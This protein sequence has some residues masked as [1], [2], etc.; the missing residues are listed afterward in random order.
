MAQTSLML[1]S[2]WHCFLLPHV[3]TM[4]WIS[5][6]SNRQQQP[7]PVWVTLTVGSCHPPA[8]C[9]VSRLTD[10]IPLSCY[11]HP[12]HLSQSPP[13]PPGI[14]NLHLPTLLQGHSSKFGLSASLPFSYPHLPAHFPITS[15]VPQP[16]LCWFHHPLLSFVSS[17]NNSG[18]TQFLP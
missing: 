4:S 17:H 13:S 16:I 5:I 9:F 15:P 7:V 11:C 18:I 12:F 10:V 6:T 8:H 2:L 1:E 3:S 14:S